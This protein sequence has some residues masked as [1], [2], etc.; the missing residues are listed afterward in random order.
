MARV[1]VTITICG[2]STA[3][4]P[5]AC[6]RAAAYTTPPPCSRDRQ[7]NTAQIRNCGPVWACSQDQDPNLD[8][9]P[10]HGRGLTYAVVQRTPKEAFSAHKVCSVGRTHRTVWSWETRKEAEAAGK[11]LGQALTMRDQASVL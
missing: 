7:C 8:R 9:G 2:D 5:V 4:M 1:R 11:N 6:A 3:E 10:T